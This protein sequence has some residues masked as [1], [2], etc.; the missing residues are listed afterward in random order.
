[1]TPTRALC[2]LSLAGLVVT[3][4]FAL[5]QGEKATDLPA[6]RRVDLR[7]NRIPLGKA[8]VEVRRQTGVAV[9]D[10]RGGDEPALSLDLRGATFWQALDQIAAAAGAKVSLSSRDGA[11]AL[12]RSR[13]GEQVPPTSY[14]GDFRVQ[15]LRTSAT[16]DLD[17]DRSSCLLS[18][19]VAW[20]PTLRPLFLESQVQELRVLDATGKAVATQEQGSSL[21][22]VDGRI[23]C[24]IDLALPGFP[25][26]AQHIGEVLGKL[27]AVAPSKML[28]FRFDADLK[29]MQGAAAGGT[30]RRLVQEGVV[31]RI[32]RTTLERSRW[33]IT[34]G[35]EYPEGGVRLES[36]QS[37]S[38]VLNNELTLV[39]KDGK[40]SLSSTGNVVESISSRRAQVTYHFTDRPR[41]VRGAPDAWHLVYR[42]P[43]RIVTVPF[44]FSFRKLPLP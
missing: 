22:P 23:S 5:G 16:R 37:G 34:V 27:S 38:M 42:A 8:L 2:C 18:L 24:A 36:Y 33:S 25:R 12:V 11:L 13:A 9:T 10:E 15:V 19:E 39:S 4:L 28:A 40:R 26:S 32:V 21:V 35:L 29:T 17:S 31:C 20:T 14:D 44:S 41:M 7:E 6:V 43:A 30:V 1:M 3:A